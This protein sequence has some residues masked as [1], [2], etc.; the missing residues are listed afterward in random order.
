MDNDRCDGFGNDR[1]CTAAHGN[2]TFARP[3]T[4]SLAYGDGSR[5]G[6]G[7]Y[8]GQ[9]PAGAGF[10]ETVSFPTGRGAADRI[11]NLWLFPIPPIISPS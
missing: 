6:C 10:Y 2:G 8:G 5:A 4:Q 1:G 9:L 11:D 7:F 3:K